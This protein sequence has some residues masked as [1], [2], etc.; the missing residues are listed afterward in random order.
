MYI[1]KKLYLCGRF[2][3]LVLMRKLFVK[4]T[5]LAILFLSV[6]IGVCARNRFSL[7][8]DNYHFGYVTAGLGYT[9]LSYH[10]G[11]ISAKG[12]VGC[13]AG[14]GYEFRRHNAWVSAGL[15]FQRLGSELNINDYTYTPPVGGLDDLGRVVKEYRYSI[16]QHDRQNWMTLDIPVM[17]GYYNNGFYIGAG[18]KVAFPVYTAGKVSGSYDIDALYDRYV[19]IVS[20]MHYYKTYPY[21]GNM[22]RY[23]L[24]PMVSVVGE[25]GF[26]FLSLMTTNDRLCHLLKVGIYFE[27]GLNTVKTSPISEPVTINPKNITDATINPYYATEKGALSHTVPYMVGAK[28]TY[29]IGGSRSATATWH[30]GCQ[31]YGY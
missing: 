10:S 19:G 25:V 16:H 18:F 14:F 6:G 9:S 17:A 12:G 21:E 3:N 13:L 20:D 1:K 26:D 31:C 15:Q 8:E 24:R 28:I 7:D 29:M 27:Y 4:K 23:P 11:D 22:E 30:K 5:L 2:G